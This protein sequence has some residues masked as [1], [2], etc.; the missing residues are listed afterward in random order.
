M[1]RNCLTI[2]DYKINGT[3]NRH[4]GSLEVKSDK[5]MELIGS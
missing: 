4:S 1:I 3:I 2:E 5:V